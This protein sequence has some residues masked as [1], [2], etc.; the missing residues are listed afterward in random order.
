MLMHGGSTEPH[1]CTAAARTAYGPANRSC[2]FIMSSD[3]SGRVGAR[4]RRR[5][6]AARASSSEP[7]LGV[8][9]ALVRAPRAAELVVKNAGSAMRVPQ[10]TGSTSWRFSQPDEKMIAVPRFGGSALV[11]RP[12]SPERGHSAAA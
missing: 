6:S 12:S 11:F 8:V 9:C 4:S 5:S 10:V 3:G 7:R 2:H 1:A